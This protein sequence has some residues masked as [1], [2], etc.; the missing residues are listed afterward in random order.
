MTSVKV[1]LWLNSKPSYR[2]GSSWPSKGAG[3]LSYSRRVTGL[4]RSMAEKGCD[5]FLC[6]EPSNVLYLTGFPHGLLVLPLDA[7]PV[8]FV[9]PLEYL[10]ACEAAVSCQVQK[11]PAGERALRHA[12]Q[13]LSELKAKRVW[14]DALQSQDFS[15]LVSD[16]RGITPERAAE[17]LWALRMVKDD[18]ELAKMREAS[19]LAVYG[20]AVAAETIA[21]GVTE[22]QV[23]AEAE[24]AM[25]IKGSEGAAFET[26]VSSGARS[27]MPHAT[28]SRKTIVKGELVTVDLG[29]TVGGYRSDLTRTFQ[30]GA[31]TEMQLEVAR[32]VL[33]AQRSARE[34]VKEGALCGEVDARSRR[35]IEA[36]GYGEAFVHSVGHGI[37]LDVHEPPRLGPGSA[38]ALKERNVVTVEP[39]I[40]LAGLGGFRNEDMVVVL[41]D[42]LENLTEAAPVPFP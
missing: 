11:V 3:V 35:V 39:G 20:M 8:M 18:E 24:Y 31:P 37:G 25:R 32:A 16:L 33:Q 5:A 29:A 23:A 15:D 27:A 34:A 10:A 17:R 14:Y 1:R 28:A 12:G 2:T 9:V 13:K 42:G 7:E 26:L 36:A 22:L 40:Y 41:K 19:K 30:T 38:E 21:P 4:R 6:S